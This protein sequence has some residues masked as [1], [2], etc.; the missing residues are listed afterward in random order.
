MF[1]TVA[2]KRKRI[3]IITVQTY[4]FKQKVFLPGQKFSLSTQKPD[5][6]RLNM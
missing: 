4:L 2:Y 6:A 1:A 3:I 5:D